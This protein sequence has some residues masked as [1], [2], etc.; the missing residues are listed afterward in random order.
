LSSY[1]IDP[2]DLPPE[3]IRSSPRYPTLPATLIGRLAVDTRRR[4]QGLG[5]ELQLDAL[6]RC[7]H[8]TSEIGSIAVV[9][10]AE[11]YAARVLP[12]LQF[13]PV[14]RTPSQAASARETVRGLFQK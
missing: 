7:F 4:G 14:P 1:P 9:V 5:E 10:E 13:H 12:A 11:N 3:W 6:H 2:G 8:N